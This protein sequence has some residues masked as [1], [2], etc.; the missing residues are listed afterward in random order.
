MN[1]KSKPFC[2]SI[3][4]QSNFL[5]DK[6]RD[7]KW[8]KLEKKIEKRKLTERKKE[9]KK[10]KWYESKPSKRQQMDKRNQKIMRGLER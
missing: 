3:G 7:E 9:E 4:D 2:G 1:D 6:V 5:R 10:R 8:E